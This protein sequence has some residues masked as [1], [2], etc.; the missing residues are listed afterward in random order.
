MDN[1]KCQASARKIRKLAGADKGL[2]VAKEVAP[3]IVAIPPS[4]NRKRGRLTKVHIGA[5]VEPTMLSPSLRVG[6]TMQFDLFLEDEGVLVAIPTK[7]LIREWV[8]L[9]SRATIVGKALVDELERANT[10]VVPKLKAEL[11]ESARK[12][13]AAL[14]VVE[15]CRE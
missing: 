11:E 15:A 14:E 2:A 9:Q 8:E 5:E 6:Q 10:T 12:L 1:L 3:P 7:K 13:K 4:A